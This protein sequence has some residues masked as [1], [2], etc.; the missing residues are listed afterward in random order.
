[1]K[2]LLTGSSGFLGTF[3]A[4]ELVAAGHEVRA[5]LRSGQKPPLLL[6][7]PLE[8]VPGDILDGASLDRA[9]EGCQALVHCAAKVS[10]RTV[11]SDAVFR[12]NVE[13]S[14][15]VLEA[16]ARARI[17]RVVFTSSVASM[18]ASAGP[19]L[20][21]ETA[22]WGQKATGMAYHLSK[23]EAEQLALS[24]ARAGL[25]VVLLNPGLLLGPDDARLTSTRLVMHGLNRTLPGYVEGG[26][27][28]AHV[29]DVAR[30]HVAALSFGEV[31]ERY[32]LAGLNTT[33]SEFFAL[34]AELSGVPAPRRLPAALLWPLVALADGL[35][36]LV[37][38]LGHTT[39]GELNLPTLRASRQ[40]TQYTCAKAERA[41]GYQMTPLRE[42]LLDTI[43]SLIRSGAAKANT[44]EL[45][46]LI[47]TT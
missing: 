34:V 26:F 13:G 44:P 36:R 35:V 24:H 46:G 8:V 4:R 39:V 28:A 37:P 30:A 20:L 45:R 18:G 16:A 31:G 47:S 14:R 17:A 25:P 12:T 3:V 15:T 6:A 21:D 27:S 2:V 23:W 22:P 1:M 29:R 11:D 5:L 42:T 41:L 7:L 19:Q 38:S 10:F 9:L 43:R 32:I 40:Y 33:V